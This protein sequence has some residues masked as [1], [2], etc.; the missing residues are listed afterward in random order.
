CSVPSVCSKSPGALPTD[1]PA[2]AGF[3]PTAE[4]QANGTLAAR[5]ANGGR[6]DE[7]VGVID[8]VPDQD[9]LT[10]RCNQ[11]ESAIEH[12]RSQRNAEQP[13]VLVARRGGADGDARVQVEHPELVLEHFPDRF[14]LDVGVVETLV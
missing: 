6:V 8:R 7:A 12:G 1:R 11:M 13:G 5:A 4:S 2:L 10:V 9:R 3:D 14:V